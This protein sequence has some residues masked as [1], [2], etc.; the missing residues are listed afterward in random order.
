MKTGQC[1]NGP[2]GTQ[3]NALAGWDVC[4]GIR[5]T[6]GPQRLL[7]AGFPAVERPVLR[8]GPFFCLQDR[9]TR[10]RMDA[11]AARSAASPQGDDV[12][13]RIPANEHRTACIGLESDA[14]RAHCHGRDRRRAVRPGA[15]RRG[16]R[17]VHG[18]ERHDAPSQGRTGAAQGHRSEIKYRKAGGHRKARPHRLRN[19]GHSRSLTLPNAAAR[20]PRRPSKPVGGVPWRRG[21]ST[22]S[23]TSIDTGG[24]LPILSSDGNSC[25]AGRRDVDVP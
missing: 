9:A 23:A 8:D 10:R 22:D 6:G 14:E 13:T 3:V 1:I 20:R 7:T 12:M 24:N 25:V 2:G 15:S 17:P 11:I 16:R 18:Q 4:S 21:P 19:P 5:R